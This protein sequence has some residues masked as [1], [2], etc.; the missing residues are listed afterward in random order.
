MVRPDAFGAGCAIEA[1]TFDMYS[2][3]VRRERVDGKRL[4][5][6]RVREFPEVAVF[7]D[8]RTVCLLETVKTLKDLIAHRLAEGLEL[9]RPLRFPH[10]LKD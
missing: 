7:D 5:V 1:I 3:T 6:G 9:P 8:R 2:V 10:P 4:F